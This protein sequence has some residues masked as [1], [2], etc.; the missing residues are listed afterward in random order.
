M[1]A[2]HARLFDLLPCAC[3]G[4]QD[5]NPHFEECLRKL[6]TNV[7]PIKNYVGTA[8]T[9]MNT[10]L[11]ISEI[12]NHKIQMLMLDMAELRELILGGSGGRP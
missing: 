12:T 1:E 4:R 6:E 8:T 10:L 11:E 3:V 2:W 7:A 5:V 9:N